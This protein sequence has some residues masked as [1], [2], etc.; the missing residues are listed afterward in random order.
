MVK[1]IK[2]NIQ[3]PL[4]FFILCIIFQWLFRGD[5]Q[6]GQIIGVSILIFLFHIFYD[7]ANIPYKWKKE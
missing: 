2:K 5:I 1:I 6:W 4:I 7:W 3:Y